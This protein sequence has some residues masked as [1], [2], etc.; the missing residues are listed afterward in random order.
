MTKGIGM[1]AKAALAVMAGVAAL[2][3]STMAQGDAGGRRERP[4]HPRDAK[5]E[6]QWLAGKVAG[7]PVDCI[8]LTEARSSRNIGDRTI[9][10]RVN[11]KLI[12]RNDPPGGCPGLAPGSTVIS[13]TPT[14]RLCRG[15]ILTVRDM[16]A[17]FNS[18]SCTLGAFVPYRT[19]G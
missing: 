17:G 5:V 3:A 2:G 6:A 1:T 13:Q 9:L 14:T 8:S 10:Y 15:D 19:P 18:G 7:N 11:N 4:V 12:Y 16:V